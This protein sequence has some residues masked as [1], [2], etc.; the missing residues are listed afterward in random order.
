MSSES[1][2]LHAEHP[3]SDTIA[4]YPSVSRLAVLALV[5]AAL[6]VGAVFSQLLVCVAVAAALTAVAALRSIARA[7]RPLLGRKAAVA[8]LLVSALFAA[9]GITWRAVREQVIYAGARQQAD[10]WLQLVQAG[11]LHE[12]HQLHLAH[13]NRQVPGADLQAYYKTDREARFEYESYLRSDPLRQIIEAGERGTVRF[14]SCEGVVNEPHMPQTTDVVT[15]R[16]AL[17]T[18]AP[19]QPLV[20]LVLVARRLASDGAEAE[21]ELRGLRLP[22]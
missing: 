19:G 9:W 8:A 10:K 12:A 2:R 17:D 3:E 16:Y 21:W 5:L 1:L 15:L 4:E 7:E 22:K 20:F 18:P 6:G 11:R 13:E 14:L